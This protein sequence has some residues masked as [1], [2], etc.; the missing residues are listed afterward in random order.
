MLSLTTT[1]A[2]GLLAAFAVA[3]DVSPYVN[4]AVPTGVPI[5]GN[6]TGNLRPQIHFSPPQKFM[7][8]TLDSS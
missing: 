7:V 6:Y 1:A 3:Q 2:V 8:R 5:A 4:K